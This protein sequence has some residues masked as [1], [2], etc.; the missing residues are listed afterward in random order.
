M[1]NYQ[2]LLQDL[3]GQEEELQFD[4]FT[5]D[6]ALRLERFKTTAQARLLQSSTDAGQL[7]QQPVESPGMNRTEGRE[8]RAV[9]A[10]FPQMASEIQLGGHRRPYGR[11]SRSPNRIQR[12]PSKRMSCSCSTGR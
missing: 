6:D 5:N 2:Q 7:L 8:F 12:S 4:Q 10:A 9:L 3:L 11:P 1:D